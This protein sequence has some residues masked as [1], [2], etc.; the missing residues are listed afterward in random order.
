MLDADAA[1][2]TSRTRS[3]QLRDVS[4]ASDGYPRLLLS[5]GKK[6][7]PPRSQGV[8]REA[9]AEAAASSRSRFGSFYK[10]EAMVETPSLS[11]SLT[12]V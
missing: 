1:D 2:D 8:S 6:T 7:P 3:I 11:S 9:A 4:L 12:A 5:P 10:L